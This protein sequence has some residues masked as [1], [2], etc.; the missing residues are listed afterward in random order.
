MGSP[1]FT[2][3]KCGKEFAEKASLARHLVR[4]F[5]CDRD[6]AAANECSVCERTFTNASHLR[7]HIKQFH[8]AAG[9]AAATA[10]ATAAAAVQ[11]QITNNNDNSTTNNVVTNNIIINITLAPPKEFGRES[12]DHILNLPFSELKKLIGVAPNEE[13]I[14][15]IVKAAHTRPDHPQNHNVLLESVDAESAYVFKHQSWRE[16]ERDSLLNDC[17]CD[18]AIK[19]LDFEHIYAEKL[20]SVAVTALENYRDEVEGLARGASESLRQPLY[21]AIARVLVEFTKTQPDLL[22]NAKCSAAHAA[23]AAP[24]RSTLAKVFEEWKPGG[25][26]YEACLKSI[27]Q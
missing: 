16:Q 4:K 12:V 25:V 22:K 9:A 15:N 3:E 8:S 14:A 6:A 10:A 5:P 21:D 17:A 27:K 26:R 1:V 23:D 11:Q 20:S 19:M 24:P 18:G 2:C 13:T 7:R